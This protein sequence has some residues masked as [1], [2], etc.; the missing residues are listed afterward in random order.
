ME[1]NMLPYYAKKEARMKTSEI[2]LVAFIC[3]GMA[4]LIAHAAYDFYQFQTALT[5]IEQQ[6]TC[7]DLS[8]Y[9]K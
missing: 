2:I 7:P 4:A 1:G 5:A 8:R 9:L 6:C 3:L